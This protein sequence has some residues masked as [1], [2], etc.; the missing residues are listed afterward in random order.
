MDDGREVILL[1]R[2]T[3]EWKAPWGYT[4]NVAEAVRVAVESERAAGRVYNVCEAGRPDI[5]TWVR[6]VT[7]AAGW[8]GRIVFADEPCPPPN[9]PRHLR[10]GRKRSREP[11]HGTAAIRPKKRIRRSSITRQRMLF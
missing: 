11:S 6:G 4:G 1:D 2:H 3:A 7:A 10:R 5:A 9:L 8:T